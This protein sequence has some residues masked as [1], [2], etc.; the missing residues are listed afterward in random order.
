VK[1]WHSL[2]WKMSFVEKTLIF[3]DLKYKFKYIFR[4]RQDDSSLGKK[5]YVYNL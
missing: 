3:I 4:I 2:L 5:K 1:L